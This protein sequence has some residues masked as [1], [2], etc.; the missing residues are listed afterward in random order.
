MSDLQTQPDQDTHEYVM[1]PR[2][3]VK[4]PSMA[5]S[6]H[7]RILWLIA[8]LSLIFNVVLVFGLFSIRNNARRQVTA[9][10]DSL[11]A[12]QFEDY[13]LPVNINESLPISLTV[14]FS[15]TFVVPISQSIQVSLTV[16]FSD[17][18]DV[19]IQEIIPINTTV[20]VPVTLP[21]LGQIVRIPIPI[22]T[23]IPIDLHVQV[24]ISRSIPIDT[25]I[26]VVFEVDVPVQSNVPIQ[27][28]IPVDMDFPVTIPLHDMGLDGLIQQIEQAL[29]DL[30]ESLGG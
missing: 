11:A 18:I 17:N 13:N 3:E 19:P 6:W 4:A 26:P 22:V 29:R 21:P 25:S 20:E 16:P 8:I 24:P 14:P 12:I 30:A 7:Y 1:R 27:A 10:A 2:D 23:N 9:A 15:D 28:E 5:R